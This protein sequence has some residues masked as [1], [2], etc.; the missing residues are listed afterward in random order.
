MN[1]SS[2]C[3]DCFGFLTPEGYCNKCRRISDAAPLQKGAKVQKTVKDESAPTPAANSRPIVYQSDPTLITAVNRVTH[4]IR[5][6]AVF[7]FTTICTSLLGY[8]LIGAG[9]SKALTCTNSYSDCDSGGLILLGWLV[10]TIGFI[11]GLA[12]GINEL[13]KSKP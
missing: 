4:A 12:L 13:R 8:G 11:V 10:I 2:M 1:A 7:I 9:T 3:A 6:L 5:S